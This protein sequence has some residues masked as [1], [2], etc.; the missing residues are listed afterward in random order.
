MVKKVIFAVLILTILGGCQ[1]DEVEEQS[2]E[3][4]SNPRSNETYPI[5]N[6]DVSFTIA[7]KNI[8][9]KLISECWVVNNC[10]K[11]SAAI[12]YPRNI[13]DATENLQVTKVTANEP[14]VLNIKG[15]QPE[16]ISYTVYEEKSKGVRIKT[17]TSYDNTLSIHG[18]G[19]KRVL[20]TLGWR[21]NGDEFLGVIAKGF[22]IKIV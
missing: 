20:V 9:S 21:S 17:K 10:S 6:E 15:E 22:V 18:S 3:F 19:T 5:S 7:G 4:T 13:K 11:E 1:N 14:I 2:T 8:T 16:K 12:I